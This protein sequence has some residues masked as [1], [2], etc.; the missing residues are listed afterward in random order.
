MTSLFS[1]SEQSYWRGWSTE[2]S[3]C[4]YLERLYPIKRATCPK[5]S[6]TQRPGSTKRSPVSY[7]GCWPPRHGLPAHCIPTDRFYRERKVHPLTT[8][9][10][11]IFNHFLH[12]H[13]V[14]DAGCWRIWAGWE[15][16]GNFPC[17]A[18]SIQGKKFMKLQLQ[19]FTDK[20]NYLFCW[21]CV[22]A[23]S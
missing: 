5:D 4:S 8:L 7:P 9:I 21:K 19:V 2:S 10:Q 22:R 6:P 13:V 16:C 20:G 12:E 15:V 18:S 17:R 3:S 23:G 11:L 14:G 1:P